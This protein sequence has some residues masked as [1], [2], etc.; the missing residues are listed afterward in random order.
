[1][2]WARASFPNPKQ[3]TSNALLT[4]AD[5]GLYQQA[6]RYWQQYQQ[7]F[8]TDAELERVMQRLTPPVK[9]AP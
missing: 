8:G 4:A 1:M 7:Q 2:S 3:A 9:G 6:H 5:A